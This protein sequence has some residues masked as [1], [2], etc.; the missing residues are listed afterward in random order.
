MFHFFLF[1]FYQFKLFENIRVC[2]SFS[3]FESNSDA[4]IAYR[5]DLIHLTL[6]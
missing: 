2:K 6:T 4:I 3:I 5:M 1:L